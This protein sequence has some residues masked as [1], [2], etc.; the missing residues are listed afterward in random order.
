[1]WWSSESGAVATEYVLRLILVAIVIIAAA[2]AFGL[3]LS[4][5]F[6]DAC[7]SVSGVSC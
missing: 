5:K 2:T 6:S 7:N 3:A 4:G 1:V